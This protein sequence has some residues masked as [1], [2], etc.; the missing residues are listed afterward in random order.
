MNNYRDFVDTRSSL[1][2]PAWALSAFTRFEA[3]DANEQMA[4][5]DAA[6]NM[7]LRLVLCA[8]AATLL[9]AVACS[10]GA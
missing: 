3:A 5:A 9:L 1:P 6:D 8:A 10:L 2:D 7:L 4:A